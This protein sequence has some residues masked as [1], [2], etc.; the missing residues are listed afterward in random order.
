VHAWFCSRR[1]HVGDGTLVVEETDFIG[2]K[3][4]RLSAIAVRVLLGR[5]LTSEQKLKVSQTELERL[6][7]EEVSGSASSNNVEEDLGTNAQ[8]WSDSESAST[9]ESP[10]SKRP[11]LPKEEERLPKEENTGTA[12][13][14]TTAA[15]T[16]TGPIPASSSPGS[17]FPLKGL[18]DGILQGKKEF[19]SKS[20]RA[21]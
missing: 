3:V 16:L 4:M 18:M 13:A 19:H 5:T 7:D 6:L 9:S 20:R 15:S 2:C 11:R 17:E 12:H 8:Q 21:R 1:K 10:P 14:T